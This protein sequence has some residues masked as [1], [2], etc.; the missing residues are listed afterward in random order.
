MSS[1]E[2]SA[3]LDPALLDRAIGLAWVLLPLFGAVL[4]TMLRIAL[5][6]AN[7]PRALA[8]VQDAARRTKLERLFLRADHLANS[9]RILELGSEF[10][11]GALL[12]RWLADGHALTAW[13]I[14]LALALALPCLL[15]FAEAVPTALALRMG[16]RILIAV[17]PAFDLVQL[18]LSWLA[19]A[20]G[21]LRR[22]LLRVVG[23]RQDHESARTIVEELRE[24][25]E[26]SEISGELDE[27][28]KEIIGNVME[29]RDVNVAAL[30][31]PRT[32]I[33]GIELADGLLGAARRTAESG[34]SRIPVY[35]GSLDR[36]VGLVTARDVLAVAAEDG[37]ETQRLRSILRPAYFVPETK[38]VSELLAEFKREKIKL[39]IV[40]DEYG[41]TAGLVTLGDIVQEIVGDIQDEFDTQRSAPIRR[42][43]NGGAE[44][45]AALHVSEVNE[46]LELALPEG[47]D[48]ETLAGFVL[49]ELGHFPKRGEKLTVSGVEITVLEASDRR[50]F[51]VGLRRLPETAAQASGS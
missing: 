50:V 20:F 26:D 14:V 37:L 31:T 15:V 38:R 6:R 43:S 17:L 3:S 1:N 51:K 7:A 2:L 46:E 24:V 40:L 22:A 35:E 11:Y 47:E 8:L 10:A 27:T 34:H 42:L 9:A 29:F 5:Q 30:M 12:L 4:F 39:A 32:Q 36:I 49:S 13:T 48:Y 16:D 45:D 28:E 33:S 44:V 21:A 41:G 25:I 23:L 18:P 19:V